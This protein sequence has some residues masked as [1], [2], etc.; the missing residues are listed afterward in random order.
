MDGIQRKRME[1]DRPIAKPNFPLPAIFNRGVRSESP[2]LRKGRE[3][4]HF[5]PK[6]TTKSGSRTYGFYIDTEPVEQQAG[7]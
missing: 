4:A 2:T 7:N 3:R 1:N 5:Y 6:Q